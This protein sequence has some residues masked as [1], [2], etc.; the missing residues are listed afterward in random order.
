MFLVVDTIIEGDE[1]HESLSGEMTKIFTAKSHADIPD[2]FDD[3]SFRVTA[4]NH[5]IKAGT[6]IEDSLASSSS[7]LA[8]KREA[9]VVGDSQPRK[10]SRKV[11]IVDDIVA[12]SIKE[13]PSIS[14]D[15]VTTNDATLPVALMDLIVPP[16]KGTNQTGGSKSHNPSESSNEKPFEIFRDES[17]VVVNQKQYM[18]LS[19]LGKG[20]SC[21]VHK[22]LDKNN[23]IYAFK[24]VEV[25]TS[26]DRDGNDTLDSYINE[27]EL[28][29][30][31]NGHP[32]IIGSYINLRYL[33]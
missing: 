20:G 15:E 25:S 16:T 6:V 12:V 33:L 4:M 8:K 22:V 10:K 7:K 3:I 31:L 1:T 19:V 29:K 32:R 17:V 2:T 5:G 28:L 27:I 24:R 9:V 11:I 14:D 30:K 18:K 23:N 26:G 21:T 13:S